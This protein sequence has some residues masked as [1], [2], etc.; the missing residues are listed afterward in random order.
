MWFNTAAFAV[1]SKYTFGNAGRNI[2][3]GPSL[4]SVDLALSRRFILAERK[5][6]LFEAQAFNLLNHENLN[7]PNLFADDPSAFGKIFSAKSPRQVQV[8]MRFSF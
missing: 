8:A 7:L 3:R 5:D 1:P 6:L 4:T 2:L